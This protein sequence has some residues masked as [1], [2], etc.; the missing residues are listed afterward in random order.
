MGPLK[1]AVVSLVAAQ[2]FAGE[3]AI[4]ATGFQMRVERHELAGDTMRL[5]QKDGVIELP[6]SA[7]LR[8]E[9]EF[10]VPEPAPAPIPPQASADPKA[11][12][13]QE[14]ARWGIPP[15]LL[16]AIAR[17]ESGYDPNAVS[18]KGAIGLMQL[19]PSTAAQ[20]GADPRDPKQNVAAGTRYFVD[21][22]RKYEKDPYQVRK[23][24]AAYNAGPNA[25][26]RYGGVPPYRETINYV[27]RVVQL[28]NP[29]AP[30]QKQ[31]PAPENAAS[32][33]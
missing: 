6:A 13:N 22:L 25:V 10:E 16:Q 9:P 3:Y 27:R 19:M 28:W 30:A 20:L 18:P 32:G 24:V 1:L 21:L 23:A 14:A 5:Y 17:T 26:E 4:L 29:Q 15:A 2:A 11:L 31:T 12:V 33:K 7:V 8:F